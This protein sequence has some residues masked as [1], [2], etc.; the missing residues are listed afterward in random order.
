MH[1]SIINNNNKPLATKTNKKR[2]IHRV[3]YPAEEE[4]KAPSYTTTGMNVD[5]I[6]RSKEA[7]HRQSYGKW[8]YMYGACR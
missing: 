2:Y 8:F 7:N 6:A 3:D 5:N 1:G 4:L